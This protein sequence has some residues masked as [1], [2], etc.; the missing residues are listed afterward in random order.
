MVQ[1]TG[2]FPVSSSGHGS[3]DIFVFRHQRSGPRGR[4]GEPGPTSLG[5]L[6]SIGGCRRA[7]GAAGSTVMAGVR[8]AGCGGTT[9]SGVIGAGG[10]AAMIASR[11]WVSAANAGCSTARRSATDRPTVSIVQ[12]PLASRIG[13]APSPASLTNVCAWMLVRACTSRSRSASARPIVGSGEMFGG[14]ST[15]SSATRTDG[16]NAGTRV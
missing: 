4:D 9:T 6:L 12:R 5:P 2:S 3:P 15:R 16:D 13:L 8:S 11:R 1:P 10:S 7:V 14:T